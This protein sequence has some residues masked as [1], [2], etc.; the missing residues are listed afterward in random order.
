MITCIFGLTAC[1]SEEELTA[2]EQQKVENAE[3]LATSIVPLFT[4]YLCGDQFSTDGL[5]SEEIE[6][7]FEQSFGLEVDGYAVIT[8][9][10]SFNSALDTMGGIESVGE[11]DSKIDDK[12]IVVEVEVKGAEKDAVAEIILSND[13]FL[14]LESA[15]LNPVSTMGEMMVKAA[16]NTLIGMGTVFLVL[17]LISLII[18]AMKLIP[19]AQEALAKR[20]DKPDTA[21]ESTASAPAPVQ[22]AAV[23]PA[24]TQTDECELVA[25]I[26]AAIAASRGET[27]TDGFVVRSIRKR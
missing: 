9:I 10:E 23:Q 25:V 15:A 18:S 12:Q 13:M 3:E 4:N 14:R 17:I 21:E 26:A 19:R 8:A 27:S 5:T 22:T 11:A 1:G 20:K 7:V 2:Y 16:M 6:Y 24:E